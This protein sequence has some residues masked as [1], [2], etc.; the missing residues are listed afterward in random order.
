MDESK[1]LSVGFCKKVLQQGGKEY[2]DE[3]VRKIR[4]AL[5]TLGELDYLVFKEIKIAVNPSV[6]TKKAA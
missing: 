4:D 3:Q 2:T 6:N 5:Y 1:K